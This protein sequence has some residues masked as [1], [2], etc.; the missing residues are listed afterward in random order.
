MRIEVR[1][2]SHIITLSFQP[3]C[4]GKLPKKPLTGASREWCIKDLTVFSIR[5]IETHVDTWPAPPHLLPVVIQREL[6]RPTVIR[7]PRDVRTLKNDIGRTIISDDEND[8][9]LQP[10]AQ[11]SEFPK[12]NTAQPVL[13]NLKGRT[14]LPFATA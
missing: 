12:V 8:I 4:Q 10:L 9:T 13:R 3:V 5:P 6:V 7:L 1:D 14:R 2:V 11:R